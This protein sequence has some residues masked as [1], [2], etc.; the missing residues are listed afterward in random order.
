MFKL[1]DFEKLLVA[2]PSVSLK[3]HKQIGL[4]MM[5]L[6]NRMINLLKRDV[7]ERLLYFF[8][9]LTFQFPANG[10]GDG[11]VM[12][13][14]LTH[15]DV[16]KLIASSRQTVTTFINLLEKEGLV[17]FSRQQIV[18][19]SVKELKKRLDVV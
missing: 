14:L 18:I 7:K 13:N 1:D 4:K 19:P 12:E 10:N 11:F 9:S 17:Q 15:E 3:Y 8:Y 16:A 2:K 6:E 5:R